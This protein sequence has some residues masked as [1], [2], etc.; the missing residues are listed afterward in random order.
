MRASH[1]RSLTQINDSGYKAKD[2]SQ[3][4]G[5]RENNFKRERDEL[6]DEIRGNFFQKVSNVIGGYFESKRTADTIDDTADQMKK[7][8]IKN[9]Y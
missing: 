1:D 8:I 4:K 9:S 6:I 3:T 2:V 7:R 5:V